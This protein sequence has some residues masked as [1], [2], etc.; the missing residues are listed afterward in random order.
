ME[1]AQFQSIENLL[2]LG[3]QEKIYIIDKLWQSVL[4]E[5]KFDTSKISPEQIAEID[6]RLE[7]LEKG[8]SK[9]Y[10]WQ[11][12]RQSISKRK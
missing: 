9:L 6:R 2:T 10:T 11:E 5:M 3:L 7:K 1:Y 12:V 4:N 8:E